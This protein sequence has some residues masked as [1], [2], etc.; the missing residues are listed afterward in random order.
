M[1]MWRMCIACW[2]SKATNPHSEYVILIAFPQR[3]WLHESASM[4]RHTYIAC[5][6]VS[7]YRH[8][9]YNLQLTTTASSP[10]SSSVMLFSKAQ[11]SENTTP[12]VLTLA[13]TI[14]VMLLLLLGLN[15]SRGFPRVC[16]NLDNFLISKL[17][18]QHL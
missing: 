17:R 5:L 8:I 18:L 4:L 2:I 16:W 1:T 7:F 15:V 9:M 14:S 11:F 6:V 13:Y 3:Q 10:L 12:F